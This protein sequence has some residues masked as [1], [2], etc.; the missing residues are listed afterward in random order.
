MSQRPV[1]VRV[2]PSP[3]G[4]PH[5]GTA[6]QA[7]FNYAFARRH[8]GRFVV[9]IEDTDRARSTPESE[10][11][12]IAAL[13]WLGLD[14]DEGPD[15]GGPHAPYRQSERLDLYRRH[16][17]ILVERGFAYRDF[18]GREELE[19]QRAAQHESKQFE[20]YERVYRDLPEADSQRRAGA[21]ESHV[22]RLKVPLAGECVMSDLLRGEIR[23]EWQL[24]DDQILLKSDG[25]PTYHLANVVDDRLMEISHVIRGEE[26][27]N[28]VPKHLLLY[29][30]FGWEPPVFCHLPLLR[31][32]DAAKSKLSKRKNP[33]SILYFQRA[34]FLPE[35]LLNFLGLM[36][37]KRAAGEELFS[38]QDFVAQ[39]DLGHVTLG[40]PVFDLE[41]LRWLNARYIRERYHPEALRD[42]LKAWA[43]NDA[44][45]DR[46][47]PL[48]Q[49]RLETLGDW[50]YL[51]AFFFADQ[52][53]LDPAEL[54]LRG[55]S[56]EELAAI[57]QMAV[58]RLEEL[59]RWEVPEIEAA[60]R[61]L[62]DRLGIKMRE[63]GRPFYVAISGEPASTPLFDSMAILGSDLTRIR[64]RRAIEALGGVSGKQQKLL[65]TRYRELFAR[66]PDDA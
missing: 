4:D 26:W 12:I 22:V 39:F 6:Y 3:T 30:A 54:E 34:G 11:A 21:G 15:R 59:R 42:L 7:L 43:L 2:A 13:R 33:T 56:K 57:L 53:R 29:Q 35:A 36:G 28:S 16:A 31:N 23:R 32:N 58:W 17:A 47:V 65:D 19:R 63:F 20:H 18:T 41:K 14:W 64:L 44:T 49:K 9:R 5:V 52:V 61:E 24:V 25:F 8:G 45:L 50:G 38:L 10:R 37:V 55:Q 62:A 51:T 1:R 46:I 48:A 27:I 60:L 40:G 66:S